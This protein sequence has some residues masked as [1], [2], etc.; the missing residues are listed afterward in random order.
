[1]PNQHGCDLA[2]FQQNATFH[3]SIRS[4]ENIGRELGENGDHVAV[5]QQ[6]RHDGVVRDRYMRVPRSS[7]SSK[8]A[9]RAPVALTIKCGNERIVSMLILPL[10]RDSG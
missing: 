6:V 4:L 8:I 7:R 2:E 3:Q 5:L 1:M 10:D 9:L